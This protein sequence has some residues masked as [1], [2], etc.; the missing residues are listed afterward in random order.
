VIVKNA[1]YIAVTVN[2]ILHGIHY[3]NIFA[4]DRTSST[5]YRHQFLFIV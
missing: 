5:M 4:T 3:N 2:F 1:E